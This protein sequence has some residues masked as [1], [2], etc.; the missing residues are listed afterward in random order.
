M[1]ADV[2]LVLGNQLTLRNP[3][4]PVAGAGGATVL[5]IEAPGE[6]THVWSHKARIAVFLAAMRHFHRLLA[7][8][9]LLVE[10]V[11]L[12]DDDAPEFQVRLENALRRLGAR[13][14]TVAEPGDHRV[15]EHIRAACERLRVLLRVQPD[16]HFIVS[17]EE[18][19]AWAGGRAT[20]RME[21]F[22]RYVRRRTGIL[23]NGS[24][25]EGG[26]W[27]LDGENRR[28]FGRQGPGL[29]PAPPGFV[30]DALTAEVLDLVS[31]RF[32]DHPGDLATFGWPVTREQALVA[33]KSFVDD[34]LAGFGPFQ[35]AMWSRQ[36]HLWH[37]LLSCAL[38]LELLDPRE[39]IDAALEAYRRHRLPLASVE[40]FVRQILGWREFV[41]GVYWLDMPGL[42]RANHYG[43]DRPLPGW[44][45]T[46]QT[47][48]NCLR[49]AIGQT[50][51]LGYAHHIQRLMVIGNFALLAG[52]RPGEVSD[53]FLAVYVDAVE[54]VELPNTAGMALYANGGRFTSKP[55]VASGA[56]IQRMS[57][58]CGGCRYDPASRSGAKACPV[59][60]LYWAFIDRHESSLSSNPRTTLMARSVARLESGERR[61]LRQE[62][63]RVLDTME[64]L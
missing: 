20:L 47:G 43:H 24:E 25:P 50:L 11:R 15:A 32:A 19:R 35:D 42:A 2:R 58:Y 27:N 33:L 59:T 13:T 18:F 60:L 51:S 30:P 56:Y 52:L 39:V 10:Y 29:V 49:E 6:S 21:H 53:W 9:G 1:T 61:T 44:F 5:M 38:N 7:G 64:T 40:G 4:L 63:Q 23:M 62:A 31:E 8:E 14:L 34:R 46:G 37:S 17:T 3:A 54:W 45:W 41:R 12:D 36:P 16:T 55:Y 48:M 57:D 26:V 28:G 22:Y